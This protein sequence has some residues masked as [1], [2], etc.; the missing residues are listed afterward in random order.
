MTKKISTILFLSVLIPFSCSKDEQT[1]A[2]C[3]GVAPTYTSDI[4]AIMN[5]SCAISGC[6]SAN[7]PADGLDLSNYSKVKSASLN[8]E[9]LQSIKHLS[10][11]E[12]MPKDAAKLSSDKILKVECW[13]KNG[14][15]E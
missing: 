13:I 7:F 14:A 5:T 11:A 4:G 6:H 15:P 3:T 1:T 12:A 2:D 9:V 10:G 8:G